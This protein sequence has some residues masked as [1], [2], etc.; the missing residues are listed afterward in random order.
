MVQYY[1]KN[2]LTKDQS[3]NVM[4]VTGPAYINENRSR[5]FTA[6]NNSRHDNPL[7]SIVFVALTAVHVNRNDRS[8]PANN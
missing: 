5:G 3:Y 6:I 1:I 4:S 8:P 7:R 2:V